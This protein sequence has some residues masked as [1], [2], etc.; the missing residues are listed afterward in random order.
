ML[1]RIVL[2][3][4]YDGSAYVGWQVQPNGIAVQQVLGEAL[5]KLTGEKC[6]LHASGR[7]D[8]G[9]HARAQVAHFDTESR[10]PADKFAFALNTYLPKD[11]RIKG[12]LALPGEEAGENEFHSRF[13]VRKKHYRYA[14]LNTVH[15]S[16][17]LSRRALH[18]YNKLDLDRLN[19]AARL[20]LG[21]HDFAAFK[22]VGSKAATTVRTIYKS[23]WHREGEMLY[24]DVAGSGFLYNMVRIMVGTMLRIGQGYEDASLI[25]NALNSPSRENAGDT[26]PAHGLTLWRVEYD[27]FDTDEVLKRN[28]VGSE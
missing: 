20:F 15:D 21:T 3:I 25:E 18:I 1:N 19:A 2:V 24:Y 12:S 8:S 23:E 26:A 5:F 13:S 9:V 11:I 17:F 4:E 28:A 16:A 7:T 22:A 14:V 10:I 6:T 27:E